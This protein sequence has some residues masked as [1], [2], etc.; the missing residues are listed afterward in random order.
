[1]KPIKDEGRGGSGAR[2]SSSQIKPFASIAW[3]V[4][5]SV[6]RAANA[7]E[8]ELISIVLD[9][10]IASQ[11]SGDSLVIELTAVSG[12]TEAVSVDRVLAETLLI[13]GAVRRARAT[14]REVLIG[15]G[16][17]ILALKVER[18]A[19]TAKRARRNDAPEGKHGSAVDVSES[20][21]EKF[22]QTLANSIDALPSDYHV[23]REALS[24]LE[25][26]ARAAIGH[27][28]ES[29]MNAHA[30]TLP[31]ST[32][33][34]KK[35]LAR[36]VNHE[37][38]EF[39]LALKCP[40]TGLPATLVGHPGW[41]PAVGRFQFEVVEKGRRPRRTFSSVTLPPLELLAEA[42]ERSPTG[43]SEGPAR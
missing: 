37:L 1:M 6:G 39:R 10:V 34:E 27:A 28:L 36:W 22:N 21:V 40:K 32:Y 5:R 7:S 19:G 12:S 15:V 43:P 26:A 35:A 2:A 11:S 16:E 33:D 17:L 38:R 30:A 8:A 42:P 18:S 29:A 31:Q 3:P 14:G 23:R 9:E 25:A 24:A 4:K 41:D 20:L 13:G